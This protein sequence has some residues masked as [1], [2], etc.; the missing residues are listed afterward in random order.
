MWKDAAFAFIRFENGA[1]VHLE[2]S[3]AGNL[4]DDIPM[5]QYFGRELNNS[6]LRHEGNDP[7][8]AADVVRRS[9]WCARD[10]SDRV[11]G[12]ERQF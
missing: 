3:W 12:R 6:T 11:T 9:R 2:T 8:E 5:G 10:R 7:P 4:P 1:V